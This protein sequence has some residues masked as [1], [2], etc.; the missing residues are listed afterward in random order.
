[1]SKMNLLNVMG[2]VGNCAA[3][4]K[5]VIRCQ[6]LEVKMILILEIDTACSR[7]LRLRRRKPR[8]G[9]NSML[10]NVSVVEL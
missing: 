8:M 10:D 1:M 7:L 3:E 4:K 2:G 6:E 5:E 9:I